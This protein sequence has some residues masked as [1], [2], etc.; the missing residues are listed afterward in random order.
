MSCSLRGSD[1]ILRHL[2]DTLGIRPGQTTPDGLFTLTTVECLASCGTAPMM[3]VNDG[4]VENLTIA[5]VNALLS[6][7]A[8]ESTT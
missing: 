8:A 6:E 1:R 3:M 2:T 5:S 7:L 4:Y